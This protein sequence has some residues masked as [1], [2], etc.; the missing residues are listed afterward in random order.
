MVPPVGELAKEDLVLIVGA[1][2]GY[3]VITLVA[4]VWVG[5]A[6]HRNGLVFLVD[7]VDGRESLAQS[8]NHLLLVGF[9]LVNIG[10]V[11][12][13]LETSRPP[14]DLRSAIELV[15][16][17]VGWALLV[18]GAMHFFNL[19]VLGRFRSWAGTLRTPSASSPS[20]PVAPAT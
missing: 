14:H 8:I 18:L 4:T 9:Y 1:Y 7:A 15:S 3:L 10:W 6:L 16:A 2:S 19:Y 12:I 13:A 17:K 20:D 5:R 11:S